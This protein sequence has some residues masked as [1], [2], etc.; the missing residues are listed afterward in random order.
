[1][2]EVKL[3]L[4]LNDKIIDVLRVQPVNKECT[5]F[6]LETTEDL[7]E[8]KDGAGPVFDFENRVIEFLR[9]LLK[10]KQ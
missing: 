9:P 3:N 7:P 1:M 5:V 6:I 8:L 4:V 2:S 10:K